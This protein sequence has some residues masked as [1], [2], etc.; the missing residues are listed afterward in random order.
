MLVGTPGEGLMKKCYA[1]GKYGGTFVELGVDV[2]R[3]SRG[4][5]M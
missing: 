4:R 2:A 1:W 3:R 5:E